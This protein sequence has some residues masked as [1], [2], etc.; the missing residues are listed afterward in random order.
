MNLH[1]AHEA[2]AVRDA[3]IASSTFVNAR[4]AEAHFDDV[5]LRS[6]RFTNVNLSGATFD[7]VN[8]SNISI[9]NANLTGA[10]ING[11]AIYEL[12]EAHRKQ[13]DGGRAGGAGK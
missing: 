11:I 5:D 12:L 6:S 3:D 9:S 10:R 13:A 8:L 7:D 4:L 2:I 1:N